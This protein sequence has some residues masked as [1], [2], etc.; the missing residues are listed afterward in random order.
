MD[1]RDRRITLAVLPIIKFEVA[2]EFGVHER[3]LVAIRSDRRSTRARWVCMH[4]AW[5]HLGLK[6][7]DVVRLIGGGAESVVYLSTRRI[8]DLKRDP[9]TAAQIQKLIDFT[10]AARDRARIFAAYA[11]PPVDIPPENAATEKPIRRCL[12][13]GNPFA[14]DGPGNRICA[15]CARINA[16]VDDGTSYAIVGTRR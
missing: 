16:G 1:A 6:P 2:R 15:P 4:L 13:C 8:A 11:R 7:V 3:Q 12:R 10:A 9:V 5:R 14:S